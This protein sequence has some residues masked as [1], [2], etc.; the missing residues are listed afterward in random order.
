MNLNFPPSTPVK[1]PKTLKISHCPSITLKAIRGKGRD[2]QVKR[3]AR[4]FLVGAVSAA[5]LI[6][7]TAAHSVQADA[8]ISSDSLF[9]LSLEELLNIELTGAAR[10][11]QKL[12]ETAA[13]AFV[14]TAEDIRR[15]GAPSIAEALRMVPGMHVAQVDGNSYGISARGSNDRYATKML[16]MIDGRSVYTPTY[17]GIYW[18]IQDI[19]MADIERIEVV[20]GPG[21]ALWGINAVNGVINVITR[22]ASDTQDGLAIASAGNKTN[23]DLYGRWGGT[24]GPYATYRVYGQV[25]DRD[26]NQDT[27]GNSTE[28]TAELARVGGRLDWDL[29]ENDSLMVSGDIYSVDSGVTLAMQKFQ[30]PYGKMRVDDERSTDG[31]SLVGRWDHAAP[32]GDEMMAQAYIDFMDRDDPSFGEDKKTIELDAQHRT[33]RIP[34]HDL[35][36]GVTLRYHDIDLDSSEGN[37]FSKTNHSNLIVSAFIQDEIEL[38][39][40][41]LTLTLGAKLEYNDNSDE[42][43]EYMPTARL[44]WALDERNHMWGAITKAVRTPNLGEQYANVSLLLEDFFPDLTPD[45]SPVP[46][47]LQLDGSGGMK[48][49]D[50]LAYELGF[51]SQVTPA[52]HVDVA[53]YY[54]DYENLR[55]PKFAGFYCAPANEPLPGCLTDPSLPPLEFIALETD[56]ANASDGDSKGIE[57]ALNWQVLDWWQLVGAYTYTDFDVE[58]DNVEGGRSGSDP[59]QLFS[60]QSRHD[61]GER[62]ALDIWVRYAGEVDAYN[63]DDYWT[64]DLRLAWQVSDALE[65]SVHGNGLLESAHQEFESEL[66]ERVPV[67]IERS[68]RVEIRYDF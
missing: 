1:A 61:L 25:E 14:I 20:R 22:N 36:G 41:Q 24:L 60:L 3:N 38:L 45:V 28:D 59:D 53:L 12:S 15:S 11:S 42:D 39:E 47:F 65:L 56:M 51:R 33:L 55:W 49:E 57:L 8:G 17:S 44:M 32:G 21:S 18:D 6:L 67:E 9:D 19:P 37:E 35:M 63:I 7:G 48:S 10:K 46:I 34:G 68:Y 23:H 30:P 54:H 29:S 40:D 27:M 13:A 26:G 43:L 4:G 58:P 64:L 31:F 52:L 2:R 62:A 16:M 50:L 66:R 5:G